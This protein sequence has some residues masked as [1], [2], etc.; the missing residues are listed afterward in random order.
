MIGNRLLAGKEEKHLERDPF[1][2]SRGHLV[3]PVQDVLRHTPVLLPGFSLIHGWH[4]NIQNPE[5]K[6]SG[7]RACLQLAPILRHP[8]LVEHGSHRHDERE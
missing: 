4:P 1:C 8:I 2:R 6:S 7:L 5:R 3:V